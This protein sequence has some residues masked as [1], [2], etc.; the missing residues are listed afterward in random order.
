MNY[1]D[2]KLTSVSRTPSMSSASQSLMISLSKQLQEEKEARRKLEK[3]LIALQS[4]KA[5][6]R[7]KRTIKE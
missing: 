6:G 7:S 5:D 3:D 2:D 4:M 1:D